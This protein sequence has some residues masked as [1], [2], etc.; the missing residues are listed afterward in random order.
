MEKAQNVNDSECYTASSESIRLYQFQHSSTARSQ[1]I[2]QSARKIWGFHDGNYE[3]CRI[4]GSYAV[5]LL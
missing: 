1:S 4:L 5:W 3:E 2:N